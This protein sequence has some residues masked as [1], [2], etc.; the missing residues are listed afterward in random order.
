LE[1]V[2][3]PSPTE[4]TI[5]EIGIVVLNLPMAILEYKEGTYLHFVCKYE[6]RHPSASLMCSMYNQGVAL[7]AYAFAG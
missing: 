4:S 6:A 2:L 7:A 1:Y 5:L 3:Q